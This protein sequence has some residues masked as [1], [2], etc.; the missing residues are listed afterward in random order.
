MPPPEPKKDFDTTALLIEHKGDI[1]R[2]VEK[3][4]KCYSEERYEEFQIAVERITLKIIE[5]T[6]REKIK[7]HAKEAAKEYSE[8]KGENK[9]NFWTPN[10]I[11]IIIALV[12]IIALIVAIAK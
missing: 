12:A 7:L 3:V 11:Q 6:G 9:K 4:A 2:L 10:I 5:G 1:S 8:E